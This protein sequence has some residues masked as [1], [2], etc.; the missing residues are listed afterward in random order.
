MSKKMDMSSQQL[1]FQEVKIIGTR[2]TKEE[3]LGF[4]E[5]KI[6]RSSDFIE[7][8]LEHFNV[9][10]TD[11]IVISCAEEGIDSGIHRIIKEKI[12]FPQCNK[13]NDDI[14]DRIGD[15]II[16]MI[17]TILVKSFRNLEHMADSSIIRSP[18]DGRIVNQSIIYRPIEGKI[19]D[20]L[21]AI[22]HDVRPTIIFDILQY[23]NLIVEILKD[24]EDIIERFI[25]NFKQ[26][27]LEELM[28][29]REEIDE[30]VSDCIDDALDIILDDVSEKVKSCS[31][32]STDNSDDDLTI[33]TPFDW[34]ILAA[35]KEKKPPSLN[36]QNLLVSL[37]NLYFELEEKPSAGRAQDVIKWCKRNVFP[38]NLTMFKTMPEDI[39]LMAIG[40]SSQDISDL[41]DKWY[42]LK[43]GNFLLFK[44]NDFISNLRF[45]VES[46]VELLAL[47]LIRKEETRDEALKL[48]RKS[49]I[50]KPDEFIEKHEKNDYSESDFFWSTLISRM[51]D[52][53]P[54]MQ[55][56]FSANSVFGIAWNT[57]SR[58]ALACDMNIYA[59]YEGKKINI[60]A[61]RNC[62]KFYVKAS[63][64]QKDC[65]DYECYLARKRTSQYPY[66]EKKREEKRLERAN[67]TN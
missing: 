13:D 33:Y 52:N 48:L 65:G 50:S 44:L 55:M 46:T 57:L 59:N 21:F 38:Y 26:D 66:D 7:F 51:S 1:G 22:V 25:K 54:Q 9:R 3:A 16:D 40:G 41:N 23:N 58:I 64:N 18:I 47:N 15:E 42:F 67:A 61:C 27:S 31:E 43:E 56:A 11:E 53:I 2:E 36:N 17:K 34:D 63:N 20:A 6:W 39:N 29:I 60:S 62:G 35:Y 37:C 5:Y 45:I 28:A 49:K 24:T 4:S 30:L 32:R 8:N 10:D 14:I 12:I 19:E